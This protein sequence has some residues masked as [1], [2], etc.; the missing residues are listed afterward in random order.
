MTNHNS[1]KIVAVAGA[2]GHARAVCSLMNVLNMKVKYLLDDDPELIGTKI[3]GL[4]VAGNTDRLRNEPVAFVAIGNNATRKKIVDS[5]GNIEFPNF[6][7]PSAVISPEVEIGVGTVIMA[8]AIIQA[9]STIGNHV[10]VN[11]GVVIEHDCIL[12]DYSHIA[13]NA[14]LAGSCTLEEGAFLGLN[15][16]VIEG[17]TIGSWSVVG[18]AACVISDIPDQCTAV[19]VPARP[20][21]FHEE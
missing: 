14:T 20:M 4:E 18:A 8:G 5:A 17:K 9:G 21:K 1:E 3:H 15:A 6:I 11:S 12:D 13:P 2:G 7:H 16:C 19:G 10:I